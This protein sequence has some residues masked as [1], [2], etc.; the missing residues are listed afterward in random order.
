MV[1]LKKGPYTILI[2]DRG[3]PVTNR[4]GAPGWPA[5]NC[6]WYMDL[7]KFCVKMLVPFFHSPL[8]TL[9]KVKAELLHV[10]EKILR[11]KHLGHKTC[12]LFI[13]FWKAPMYRILMAPYRSETYNQKTEELRINLAL[14]PVPPNRSP[15][16]NGPKTPHCSHNDPWHQ[17]I[18]C[19][20]SKSGKKT[21][22]W[23]TRD[24]LLG[25]FNPSEK[26]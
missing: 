14:C 9:P 11:K 22:D 18:I 5:M 25:G 2:S 7:P 26:Y 6:T 1:S 13:N 8:K 4:G 19:G 15:S 16:W 23:K 20:L 17:G 3:P 10:E 12:G 24:L 21:R